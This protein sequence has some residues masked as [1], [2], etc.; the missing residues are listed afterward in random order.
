MLCC[1]VLLY[2]KLMCTLSSYSFFIYFRVASATNLQRL[3]YICFVACKTMVQRSLQTFKRLMKMQIRRLAAGRTAFWD[4]IAWQRSEY[5]TCTWHTLPCLSQHP[6]PC[7]EN[8]PRFWPH[9]QILTR[10][11][12][13]ARRRIAFSFQ[14][15]LG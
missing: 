2:C 15:Y 4:M 7:K 3:H 8:M 6:T 5:A 10:Q 9:E 13:I 12:K 11:R 14:N 1:F